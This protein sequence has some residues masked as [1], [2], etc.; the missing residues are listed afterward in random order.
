[1]NRQTYPRWPTFALVGIIV[2]WLIAVPAMAYARL[3]AAGVNEGQSQV[4]RSQAPYSLWIA[5][6]A[7]GLPCLAVLVAAM[8][9]RW[10]P[11]VAFAVIAIALAVPCIRFAVDAERALHWRTCVTHPPNVFGCDVNFRDGLQWLPGRLI[12]PSAGSASA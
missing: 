3:L 2:I 4:L 10:I 6:V 7:L 12:R 8:A 11:C 1:M 9:G 5:A